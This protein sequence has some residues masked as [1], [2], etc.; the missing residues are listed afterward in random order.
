MITRIGAGLLSVAMLASTAQ[1]KT[2]TPRWSPQ[3][4]DV[5]QFDVLR[6]GKP[7]GTHTVSFDRDAEGRLIARSQVELKAGLG[8]I[9]VFRYNLDATEVWQDGELVSLDGRVDDDGEKGQVEAEREGALLE[10][11]GTEFQGE[12]DGKILPSSHWNFAQTQASELLSTEDGEIL[13]VSVSDQG[14]ETIEAAG[15]PVQ[16]T[17]YLMDSDIDVTL[18]YDDAGRWMKLAFTA[19]GQNIEYVLTNSY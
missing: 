18:W 11:N 6:K 2:E 3:A 4:G 13:K 5:I 14:T 19:R 10:V 8:P 16:T 1:A 7:F 9:T 12:V 15:Q 17:R